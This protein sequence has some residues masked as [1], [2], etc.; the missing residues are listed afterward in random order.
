[1]TIGLLT[2]LLP[3]GWLYAFA[4]VAA[5]AGS[6][7]WGAAMMGAFWMGTVPILVSLGVGVQ[8]LAG[9]LGRR[10]P[11]ATALILVAVGL[12]TVADRLL[13]PAGAFE[14]LAESLQGGETQQQLEAV[15]RAKPPCCQQPGDDDSPAEVP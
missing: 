1:L 2:A 14:P 12:Y 3:C 13:V 11:L 4:I 10:L 8:A 6:A 5:G 9:A 15:G 7:S